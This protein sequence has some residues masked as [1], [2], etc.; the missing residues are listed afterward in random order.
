VDLKEI[1]GEGMNRIGIA[2]V[3]GRWRAVGNT[4]MNYQVLLHAGKFLTS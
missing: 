4:V 3:R 1:V 2:Y